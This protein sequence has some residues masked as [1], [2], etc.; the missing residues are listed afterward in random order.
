M[1]IDDFLR[2]LKTEKNAS[3]ATIRNYGEAMKSFDEFLKSLDGQPN[4]ETADT[5]M[6]RD[7]VASLMEKGHKATYVCNELSGIKSMYRFALAHNLVEKDPAHIVRG[8]KKQKPLP[9]FLKESEARRLFDDVQ[10]DMSN[11]KDVRTRTLLLLLYTT[12]IRRA[13]VIALDN[14]DLNFVN[15]EIKV[16][17]KRR[18]Q[19]IIPI[20]DELKEAL[21]Q[22]ITMRDEVLG[23]KAGGDSPLF[24]NKEGGRL[25]AP[26]AYNA[27]HNALTL[28]TSMKKRSPHVLRHSFATSMLNHGARL[29]SVQKLLG[30]ESIATTEIYTHVTFEDLKRIYNDAHP[31]ANEEENS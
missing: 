6:V 9:Q 30:H 20:G 28:V 12:G 1:I 22:Y 23:E 14:K 10:W 24:V 3:P 4:L 19:R 16:T 21:R 8:P 29:G 13:E 2:Y 7:W 5:D 25:T 17:G 18:K 15:S 27:V 26:Q 11:I 31:R